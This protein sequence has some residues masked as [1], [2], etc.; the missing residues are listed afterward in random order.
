[1]SRALPESTR[2]L[3]REED[4]RALVEALR[5]G[6]LVTLVGPPGVG[7]T[8]LA[9]ELALR[10]LPDFAEITCCDLVEAGSPMDLCAV[11]A[12]S[13]DADL[14]RAATVGEAA[15]LLEEAIRAREGALLCLDNFEHLVDSC[16]DLVVRWAAAATSLLVTSRHRLGLDQERCLELRP[17]PVGEVGAGASSPAVGLFLDRLALRHSS[18]VATDADLALV[19]R[20]VAELDG[21]PLAIELCAARVAL[22]L[23]ENLAAELEEARTSLADTIDSSMALLTQDERDVLAYASVLRGGFDEAAVAALVGEEDAGFARRTLERLAAKS[24]VVEERDGRF[25]ML[26]SIRELAA[27]RLAEAEATSEALSRHGSYFS[28]LARALARQD[29]G[30][31]AASARRRIAEESANLLAVHRRALDPGSARAVRAEAGLE[32]A[33]A[34]LPASSG[35]GSVAHGLSLVDAAFRAC[36]DDLAPNL[37][38]RTLLGRARALEATGRAAEALGSVK[39]AREV[40]AALG[41]PELDARALEAKGRALLALGSWAEAREALEAAEAAYEALGLEGH[42]A[43]AALGAGDTWFY[44]DDLAA[45]EERYARAMQ[46]AQHSGDQPVLGTA[47]SRRAMVEMELG[48]A[49]V[50][51]ARFHAAI[52]IQRELGDRAAEASAAT[53]LAILEHDLGQLDVARAR[54]ETVVLVTRELGA[55]KAHGLAALYLGAVLVELREAREA[56]VVLETADRALGDVGAVSAQAYARGWRAALLARS[57]DLESA[58]QLLELAR[59]HFRARREQSFYASAIELLAGHLDLARA[60]ACEGDPL[61]ASAHRSS[62]RRRLERAPEA[63]QSDVRI[64]RRLLEA[65]L[66]VAA[67]VRPRPDRLAPGSEDVLI[68]ERTGAWFRA[69]RGAPVDVARRTPLRTLLGALLTARLER[70]GR[71]VATTELMRLAWSDTKDLPVLQNRLRVAIATLRKLGLASSLFTQAGGYL[72]DPKREVLAADG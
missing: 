8:R 22:P 46:V 2:L 35:G 28:E 25:T 21:L 39:L 56:A 49:E 44:V 40:A 72:L 5:A 16:L 4:L 47:M 26:T 20:A 55:R 1:M 68:V 69:P 9:R 7:K 11:V 36:G 53:Y 27:E 3:G 51:H 71:P 67:L 18:F 17:L 54:L 23:T 15:A 32:A 57:G 41:D 6:G 61:A 12:R 66:G 62:A 38:A 14:S 63:A 50:A 64:A 70:P 65:A 48:R 29:A 30:P 31:G 60:A 42:A 10:D 37:E 45:A 52:E 43:R 33:L 34:L 24:L 58:A 19:G 13:L 59:G